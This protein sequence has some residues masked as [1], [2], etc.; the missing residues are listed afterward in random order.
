MLEVKFGGIKIDLCNQFSEIKIINK[1]ECDQYCMLDNSFKPSLENVGE[2][3]LK[4]IEYVSNGEK[5]DAI[6]VL[7]NAYGGV[8]YTEM[9]NVPIDMAFYCLISGVNDLSETTINKTMTEYKAIGLT[10]T[11]IRDSVTKCQESMNIEFSTFHSYL[12]NKNTATDYYDSLKNHLLS[13]SDQKIDLEKV[14]E[15]YKYLLKMQKPLN[16]SLGGIKNPIA[17]RKRDFYSTTRTLSSHLGF[18]IKH[19]TCE[20]FY[21]YLES[22]LKLPAHKV[23]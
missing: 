7:K 15:T 14:K 6:D 4:A 22:Y 1:E 11:Q 18:D 5:E 20:E 3:I 9:N 13:V 23:R 12:K 10:A 17:E 19:V 16:M 8:K 2:N 21:N